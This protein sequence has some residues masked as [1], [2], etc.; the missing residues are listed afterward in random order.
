LLQSVRERES[1]DRGDVR[2]RVTAPK[3]CEDDCGADNDNKSIGILLDRF[4]DNSTERTPAANEIEMGRLRMRAGRANRA[5]RSHKSRDSSALAG[6]GDCQ[7]DPE[8]ASNL[9]DEPGAPNEANRL[10]K[11]KPALPHPPVT[12]MI[13]NMRPYE[14]GRAS[15]IRRAKRSRRCR[16]EGSRGSPGSCE[17]REEQDRAATFFR[18]RP[19]ATG[20][21][22]PV[23]PG[24]PPPVA[25]VRRPRFG[26]L[27]VAA[28][29]LLGFTP[30]VR[31][32]TRFRGTSSG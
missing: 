12:R 5:E 18:P 28:G 3:D 13:R 26:S 30:R 21:G 8:R 15:A 9:R 23:A 22:Q 14:W 1:G 7:D 17:R 29:A 2:P 27:R 25:L 19:G 6:P 32:C 20:R 11:T 31:E 16:I 24:I 4:F 10:R